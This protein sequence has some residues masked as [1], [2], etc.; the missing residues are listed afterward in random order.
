VAKSIVVRSNDKNNGGQVHLSITAM[1]VERVAYEPRRL[2]LRLKGPN[3]GCPPVTIRSLDQR[4]FSVTRI[5]SSGG[6]ITADFDPALKGTEFTFQPTLD[7]ARLEKY[8]AGSLILTL[9]HPECKV[10][11]ILY[12]AL[13]EFQFS[14]PAL[15]LFNAEPNR[16]VLRDVWLSSNYG[17]DFEIA[18]C[19]SRMNVTEVVQ[20]EKVVSADKAS[21]RYRLRL[22]IKPPAPLRTQRA[23][24]DTLAI[25]LTNGK[26]LDLPCHVFY[27]TARSAL[28]GAG[29]L[30]H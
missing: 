4:S 26:T 1:I 15:T 14:P 27:G 5:I 24:G 9:T 13:P 21:C 23:L 11:R 16:P 2:S 29:V 30:R 20:K 12:Q 22:S 18:S 17:E 28:P 8:P 6:G 25:H 3:G 7:R 10:V 19:A